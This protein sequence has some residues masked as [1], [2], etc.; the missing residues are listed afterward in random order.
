MNISPH[1][2]FRLSLPIFPKRYQVSHNYVCG[3]KWL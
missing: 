1:F 2:Q 3:N